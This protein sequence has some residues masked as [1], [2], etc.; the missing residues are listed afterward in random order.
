MKNAIVDYETYYDDKVSVVTLGT[1]N[2]VA[3]ADAYIVGVHIDGVISQCGTLTEMGSTMEQI[4]KDPTVRC[5]AANSNFDQAWSDKYGW[6]SPNSWFCVLDQAA[7]NQYPRN[8]AGCAGVVLGEKVDKTARDQMKGVRYESLPDGEQIKMQEYCLNDCAKENE[9]LLKMPAMSPFEEEVAE[10]TRLMNRRG[11]FIDT[12]L[13][14]ADKTKLE[15][16]R[17]A[18]FREIPWHADAPPLSYPALVRHCNSIGIPAPK[19]LSKVDEE[20]T[21][22]MDVHPALKEVVGAMRKFRKANTMLKK[23]ETLMRRVSPEGVLPLDILYCGAPHTRRW[24]SKGFNVQNLDKEPMDVGNGD[25]VWSRH[26]LIPRPGHIFL[27]FDFAQIE[28]RCLN[29]L[30]GNEEMMAALRSGFS[31]YEAYLTAAKQAARVGWSGTPGTLKKEVG[32]AKYTKVKNESLGCGFGMG[33]KKYTTYANVSPEEAKMVITG[34]RKGNPKIVQ[35]WRR[36]DGLIR[37]AAHDKSKHLAMEM[38]SGDLLQY[39]SIRSNTKGYEGFVTRGDFGFSSKQGK[40]WG[41]TLTENVTQRMARDIL[42]NALINI[43]KAG[44]PVVFHAHDEGILEVPI[45]S[46][47]E[48][49]AEADRIALTPPDWAKDLPLGIESSFATAYTK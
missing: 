34:F 10:H 27:I 20:T 22:L 32:V 14:E 19:T 13:V 7:F 29:W 37:T 1:T 23:V 35:L 33:D 39:F 12:D 2:Y 6:S 45:D 18:T 3:A 25:T 48:A 36:L 49:K 8:L 26:W 16:L 41:G 47:D 30:A 17:F 9:V 46:K 40:L 28:P 15:A 4:S 38:P 43:E 44:I 21:D 11:V 31:Y 42:A 24:S 5:V